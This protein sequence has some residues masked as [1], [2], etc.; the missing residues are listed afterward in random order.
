MPDDLDKGGRDRPKRS[1]V[2]LLLHVK[3]RAFAD[4]GTYLRG[5]G[6]G[7]LAAPQARVVEWVESPKVGGEQLVLSTD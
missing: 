2:S 5:L 4:T 7:K 3:R 1:F 6:E